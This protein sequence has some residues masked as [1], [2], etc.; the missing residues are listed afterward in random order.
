MAWSSGVSCLYVWRLLVLCVHVGV[1]A[2]G[3]MGLWLD[4][5][6][7]MDKMYHLCGFEDSGH[8]CTDITK[9]VIRPNAGSQ[10]KVAI[11][12]V[13]LVW[14]GAHTPRWEMVG[15]TGKH[16]WGAWCLFF[17]AWALLK[18]FWFFHCWTP[19][20]GHQ[21][22]PKFQ[23]SK[24]QSFQIESFDSG[25]KGLIL[26]FPVDKRPEIHKLQKKHQKSW[27][28]KWITIFSY[29]CWAKFPFKHMF[30]QQ[31][32]LKWIQKFCRAEIP[33]ANTWN[34]QVLSHSR[35]NDS[36]RGRRV[37]VLQHYEM[38][39]GFEDENCLQMLHTA[40]A[41]SASTGWHSD[42]IY[43]ATPRRK[44]TCDTLPARHAL[45]MLP[46]QN[47]YKAQMSLDSICTRVQLLWAP[48]W[49]V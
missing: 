24:N 28:T 25:K 31:G 40:F 37:V 44:H 15:K 4:A 46:M 42:A 11:A 14:V 3:G 32:S 8:C 26:G 48:F 21:M 38:I 39:L 36:S 23:N 13:L 20:F 45:H 30:W 35:T 7:V 10:K 33:L 47:D 49:V 29:Q 16:V 22:E 18:S 43:L 9:P 1:E 17:K 12:L 6:I 5:A 34:R 27:T 41:T 19:K 2:A